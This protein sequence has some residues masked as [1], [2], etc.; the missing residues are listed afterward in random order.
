MV[1]RSIGLLLAAALLAAGCAPAPKRVE[2]ADQLPRFSYAVQGDLEALVRDDVRFAALARQVRRDVESVLAGHDIAETA[3]RRSLLNQLQLLDLL[4]GD[5]DA[6]LRRAAQIQALQDKPA[7]KLMSGMTVRA[8]VAAARKTGERGSPAFQAE[9]GRQLSVE[10]RRLPFLVVRND[11]IRAKTGAET[12]GEGRVLGQLRTTLQPVADRTGALSS[13]LVPALIAARYTLKV[14]LPLKPT[15]VDAYSRYLAA[16]QVDKPDIWAGRDVSLPAGRAYANVPVVVWDSGVDGALF[17]D[18]LVRRDGQPAFIAFDRQSLPS[19]SP[20][21]PIPRELQPRLPELQARSKGLSDLTSNIESPEAQQVK[22]MLSGLQPAQYKAAL[23][24]IRLNSVYQHGTHVA[25]IAMAGNP[26]ARLANARIEFGHTLLPDPC[27]GMELS[28]RSAANY[29]RYVGF[30]KAQGARVVN[31][32]W[33]GSLRNFEVALEQCGIGADVPARRALAREMFDLQRRA[34]TEALASA[35][36]VLFVVS[37]GNAANDPTFNETYPSSLVLPNVVAVG[38]VDKAGDEASFTSYGP[39]VLLHANGYQVD[40]YVPGGQRLAISGT[41]MA[42]PQVANLAAK[43][44]AVKPT[45]KP[46]ELIALM[47][48]TADR[49]DDGRRTLIHPA[50]ALA[51]AGYRP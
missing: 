12:L 13:E 14:S 11:V 41:S 36:E 49:S 25:G 47:R 39:T 34:L 21:L 46:Q 20:L 23:E 42:A 17:A 1:R 18:R 4:E 50:R 24:E 29:A 8:M 32:S 7:D 37:A 30:I 3:A 10:L 51:V 40:S 15:L 22:A 43:L 38:A 33:G 27:P 35:P 5:D 45:L 16:N 6:A 9:F 44:L 28:R 2:R 48:D 31:M 19:E 26:Y